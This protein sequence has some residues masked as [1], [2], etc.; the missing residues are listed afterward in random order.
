MDCCVGVR[1]KLP[2]LTR[3]HRE[4]G[5]KRDSDIEAPAQ[6]MYSLLVPK[7]EVPEV[8]QQVQPQSARSLPR[9]SGPGLSTRERVMVMVLGFRV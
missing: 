4:K 1:L 8:S 7:P 9:M 2:V 5:L 3:R 6:P